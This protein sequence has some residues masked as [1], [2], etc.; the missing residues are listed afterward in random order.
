MLRITL[1][2]FFRFSQRL[3]VPQQISIR[4]PGLRRYQD[5]AGTSW[6]L[7]SFQAGSMTTG[8]III[9]LSRKLSV[10]IRTGKAGIRCFLSSTTV[11]S[12]VSCKFA[13]LGERELAQTTVV[14]PIAGVSA[15]VCGQAA[16]RLK[17]LA[18]Q[19]AGEGCVK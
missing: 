8:N 6:M 11:A 17:A 2:L 1:T 14:G 16:Q 5:Q 3:V 18:A 9:S 15:A 7:S 10:L 4:S 19:L 13:A 12:H